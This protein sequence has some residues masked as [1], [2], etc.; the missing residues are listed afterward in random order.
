MSSPSAHEAAPERGASGGVDR[1][2]IGPLGGCGPAVSNRRSSPGI[3]ICTPVCRDTLKESHGPSSARPTFV[4]ATP[5]ITAIGRSPPQ[6]RTPLEEGQPHIR[7]AYSPQTPP[8]RSHLTAA[9]QPAF[10]EPADPFNRLGNH[11]RDRERGAV[12]SRRKATSVSRSRAAAPL[13]A[14]RRG[15]ARH[16]RGDDP[17]RTACG[18]SRR[19]RASPHR[20]CD[21]SPRWR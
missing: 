14:R 12:R 8:S 5:L 21:G 4:T 6:S 1:P 19:P 9:L 3:G 2:V 13:N 11:A 7:P 10:D 17:S 15:D 18:C 16:C 20:P